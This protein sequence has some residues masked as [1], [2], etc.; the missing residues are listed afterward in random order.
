MQFAIAPA[1]PQLVTAVAANAL[2]LALAAALLVAGGRLGWIRPDASA[3]RHLGADRA[4]RALRGDGVVVN[5]AL[6]VSP[7]SAGFTA[8]MRS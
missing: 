2:I 7:T 5:A 4:R 3:R 6:L 1:V 8:A